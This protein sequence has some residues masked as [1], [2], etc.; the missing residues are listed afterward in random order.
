M[1][2]IEFIERCLD[3]VPKPAEGH[4]ET[5]KMDSEL[6]KNMAREI[7]GGVRGHALSVLLSLTINFYSCFT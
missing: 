4:P 7:I 5:P 3:A 6:L 1:Y 2:T